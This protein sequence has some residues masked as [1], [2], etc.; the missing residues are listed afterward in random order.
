MITNR[1]LYLLMVIFD[2]LSGTEEGR[3][4]RGFEIATLSDSAVAFANCAVLRKYSQSFSS[5]QEAC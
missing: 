1:T 3:A 2:A 5:A 4:G